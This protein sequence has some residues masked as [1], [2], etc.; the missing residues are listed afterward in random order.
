MAAIRR[1]LTLMQPFAQVKTKPVRVRLLNVMSYDWAALSSTLCRNQKNEPGIVKLRASYDAVH[2]TACILKDP[3][4]DA[5]RP[6]VVPA[7]NIS[8]A[9]KAYLYKSVR[10]YVRPA[11]QDSICPA[12]DADV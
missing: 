3:A 7:A 5:T 6:D 9:R 11:Y 1:L 8:P 10:P 12:S 2:R 4:G